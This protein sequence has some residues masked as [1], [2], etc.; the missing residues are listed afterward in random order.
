M[1]EAPVARPVAAV[2]PPPA[3]APAVVRT[4]PRLA[5]R[6]CCWPLGEPGTAEFRFCSG[7]AATGKPYC[8]EHASV[9]YVRVRDRRE[10][11]A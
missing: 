8:S 1:P 5:S 11:A 2:A 7:T 3:P 9:A 4:F 6:T 10:D